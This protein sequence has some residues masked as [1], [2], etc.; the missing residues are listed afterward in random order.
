MK[1]SQLQQIIKEEV[2]YAIKEA[3]FFDNMN[4]ETKALYREYIQKI[5]IMDRTAIY[6]HDLLNKALMADPRVQKSGQKN[7][8]QK[9]LAW[10]ITFAQEMER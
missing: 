7:T 10:A 2:R 4:E 9:A 6:N 5:D 8:L 1:K 3:S